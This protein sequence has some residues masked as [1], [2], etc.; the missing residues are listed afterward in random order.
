MS[1]YLATNYI[2]LS[3]VSEVSD[4]SGS[5]LIWTGQSSSAQ[6]RQVTDVGD[7]GILTEGVDTFAVL[8]ATY[9]GWYVAID[10][11]TYGIFETTVSGIH[12]I[13]YDIAVAN[14]G[15][16]IPIAP[17]ISV[18]Q[19]TSLHDPSLVLDHHCFL[20][21]TL[22]ATP[23]GPRPIETLGTGDLVLTATGDVIAV[24]GLRRQD[25]RGMPRPGLDGPRAPVRI[26]AGA[27]GAGC[28][29]RD[30]IVTADHALGLD[31]LLVNAGAMVNGT[32]IRAMPLDELPTRF[33]FWHV[34]TERHC[35]L[36]AEDCPAESCAD[37]AREA[38][39]RSR[40]MGASPIP[41]MPLPR[42][43]TPRHLPAPLQARLGIR[44]VA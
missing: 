36:L 43:T 11:R 12:V 23:N 42:I 29:S 44:Q 4:S 33:D 27:L 16:G 15:H 41:E 34:E 30:L 26:R 14:L 18:A 28:P 37:Y 21:G 39:D 7:D 9:S 32:T 8:G 35:L 2:V 40:P 17:E 19:S 25:G 20:Q 10:G 13:P 38:T 31:G 22:I 6:A 24:R 1:G 3:G 5:R